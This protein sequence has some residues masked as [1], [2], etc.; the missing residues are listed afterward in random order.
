METFGA[1]RSGDAERLYL[2]FEV[3][4]EER[5]NLLTSSYNKPGA[6]G[7]TSLGFIS[8]GL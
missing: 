4:L 6:G 1:L 5:L 8:S 3:A 7:S 2:K